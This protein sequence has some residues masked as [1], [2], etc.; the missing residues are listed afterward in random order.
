[1][2]SVAIFLATCP[3]RV[4]RAFHSGIGGLA[5]LIARR[6]QLAAGVPRSPPDCRDLPAHLELQ[7]HACPLAVRVSA[8]A[9]ALVESL[10]CLAA[11]TSWA[12]QDPTRGTGGR[13]GSRR[14]RRS[15]R[16]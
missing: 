2:T 1:S 11:A 16:W 14:C 4:L 8:K 15:C 6:Y 13:R 12:D 9:A 7:L 10:E 3:L 5:S